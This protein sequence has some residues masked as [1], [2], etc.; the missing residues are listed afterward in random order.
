MDSHIDLMHFKE[1]MPYSNG[2]EITMTL[3][4]MARKKYRFLAWMC[5]EARQVYTQSEN[6]TTL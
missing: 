2:F 5:R 6:P 3:C 4:L 1:I